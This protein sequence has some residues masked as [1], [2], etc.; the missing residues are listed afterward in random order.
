MSLNRFFAIKSYASHCNLLQKLPRFVQQ[1]YF[2][3]IKSYHHEWSFSFAVHLIV[4][5]CSETCYLFSHLDF[6]FGTPGKFFKFGNLRNFKQSFCFPFIFDFDSKYIISCLRSIFLRPKKIW[7]IIEHIRRSRFWNV[8]RPHKAY[9]SWFSLF[10]GRTV[11]CW[12]WTSAYFWH[13]TRFEPLSN[14]L[15]TWN[16]G[17]PHKIQFWFFFWFL[18][19]LYIAI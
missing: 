15:E 9:K 14:V 11:H 16:L 5:Q 12:H 2:S 10:L 3:Y 17:S 18:L 8:N 4:Y 7:S 19:G 6:W 1:K 13:A